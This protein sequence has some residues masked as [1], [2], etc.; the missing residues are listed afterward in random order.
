MTHQ[1]LP[2]HG[3]S[4]KLYLVDSTLITAVGDSPDRVA[5]AIAADISGYGVSVFKSIS[6]TPISMAKVPDALFSDFEGS[7]SEGSYFNLRHDRVV[8]LAIMALRKLCHNLSPDNSIPLLLSMPEPILLPEDGLPPL[9]SE[10]CKNLN[11]WLNQNLIRCFHSGRAAGVQAIAFAFQYLAEYPYILVGGS[12]SHEDPLILEHLEKSGRLSTPE[13]MNGFVP[14]EG[15]S[16][17]LLTPFKELAKVI[18]GNVLEISEPGISEETGH[19][20]SDHPYKGEGLNSAF[21]KAIEN[22]GGQIQNIHSIYSSMN[23]ENFWAKEYGVAHLRNFT[24]ANKQAHIEHPADCFGDLGAATATALITLAA[25]HL[26]KHKN[27]H[28]HLI[29]S[30]SDT[31][32][33]GALTIENRNLTQLKNQEQL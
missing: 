7:I 17:L 22:N 5:A 33:R 13:T 29:Y 15:A 12:D 26:Q 11:P 16:F 32:L 3:K 10:L 6:D 31:S 9:P 20:Y 2:Q 24:A 19:L 18:D 30:S 21:K 8:K 4:R 23:G 1:K 27:T 25:T 28:K 14:G